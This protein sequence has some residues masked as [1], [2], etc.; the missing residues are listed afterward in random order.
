MRKHT[1]QDASL[2]G[3]IGRGLALV[4]S[5]WFEVFDLILSVQRM[6]VKSLG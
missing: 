1:L 4:E 2:Q 5:H 6:T 3:P